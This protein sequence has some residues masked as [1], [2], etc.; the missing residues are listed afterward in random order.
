M[1]ASYLVTC[2][3]VQLDCDLGMDGLGD[4]LE[5][6]VYCLNAAKMLNIS[7]F[8]PS[9]PVGKFHPNPE[10][11]KVAKLLNINIS[12]AP[13]PKADNLKLVALNLEELRVLNSA[14]ATGA[15]A[16]LCDVMVQTSIRSCNGWCDF[17]QTYASLNNVIWLLR[18]N[19]AKQTCQAHK[20]GFPPNDSNVNVVWHLRNGDVC[21]HCDRAAYYT[22][23][24]ARFFNVLPRPA[25]LFFESEYSMP[26][27]ESEPAFKDAEF[28]HN[29]TILDTVCTFLTADVLITTGS[30]LPVF[31]AAFA[32]PWHPIVIEEMRK[33][34]SEENG[35]VFPHFFNEHQAVR[36]WNG[37]IRLSDAELSGIFKSVI[38]RVHSRVKTI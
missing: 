18:C 23:I 20:L 4:Q 16:P 5:H 36:M 13:R 15:R 9:W 3:E 33:E 30:S 38:S 34:V 12:L 8:P 10:Y 26:F 32:P 31:V 6:Y 17:S 2:C 35:A 22:D 28:R 29:R 1:L 24:H 25:K 37:K 7:Y 21:L 11:P 14:I 27:L 19:M